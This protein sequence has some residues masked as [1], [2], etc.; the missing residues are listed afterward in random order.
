MRKF[1]FDLRG[2]TNRLVVEKRGSARKIRG[3]DLDE[4]LNRI[5]YSMT[6]ETIK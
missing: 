2:L 4:D 3:M 5:N 1:S 6:S